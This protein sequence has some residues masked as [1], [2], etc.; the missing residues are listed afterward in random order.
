MTGQ[1]TAING[2]YNRAAES[3]NISVKFPLNLTDGNSKAPLPAPFTACR[4]MAIISVKYMKWKNGLA[5]AMESSN[6][7]S[8]NTGMPRIMTDKIGQASNTNSP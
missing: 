1:K 7:K 2:E 5:N 3:F 4:K 8:I 6:S